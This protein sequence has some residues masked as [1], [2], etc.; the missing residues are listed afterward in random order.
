MFRN[1]FQ[2]RIQVVELNFHKQAFQFKNK[3]KF[4][5]HRT[6]NDLLDGEEDK[7]FFEWNFLLYLNVYFQSSKSTKRKTL[8]TDEEG[9]E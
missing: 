2:L 1:T 7:H 6:T 5:H 9:K 4:K 8:R 3:S